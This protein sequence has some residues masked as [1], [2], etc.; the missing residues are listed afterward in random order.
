MFRK[1]KFLD[2]QR[3]AIRDVQNM[4]WSK[5]PGLGYYNGDI[6]KDISPRITCSLLNVKK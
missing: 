4:N 3:E 2:S 1:I 5:I 6:F